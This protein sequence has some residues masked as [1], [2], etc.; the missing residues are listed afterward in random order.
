MNATCLMG[1]RVTI[2][3]S[4]ASAATML[5]EA[6]ERGTLYVHMWRYF[7]VLSNMSLGSHSTRLT[8][9]Q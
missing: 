3:R 4:V 6:L 1:H 5:L 9:Q 8:G 2:K 7:D